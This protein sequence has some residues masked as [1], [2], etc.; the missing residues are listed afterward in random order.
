MRYTATALLTLLALAAA[1]LTWQHHRLTRLGQDLASA[2]TLTVVA[3]F[4]ARAARA[5][6]QTIT[7]YV[8]RVREVRQVIHDIQRETPRYVTP[9]T[10]AAYPLPVGFVRL[11]DAAAA[12]HL[13]GPPGPADAQ[14]S[15]VKASDAAL[16]IADNYGTCL[17]VI[18]QLNALIDRLQAPPYR[19]A[20]ADD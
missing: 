5:D 1:A 12:A 7:R 2:Q 9:S 6:I 4:E 20:A 14:A 8:D 11:H 13:P 3:G 19:G 18:A 16:V 17:D 15:G 10:D